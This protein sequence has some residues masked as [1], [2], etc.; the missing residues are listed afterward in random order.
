M[1][2][3]MIENTTMTVACPRTN[4]IGSKKTGFTGLLRDSIPKTGRTN[5][6]ENAK[7]IIQILVIEPDI[8]RIMVSG[9]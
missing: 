5:I 8:A 1:T 2:N 9:F 6:R 4:E 7:N 3:F